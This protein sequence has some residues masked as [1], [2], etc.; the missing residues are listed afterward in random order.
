MVSQSSLSDRKNSVNTDNLDWIG[1]ISL[2][3]FAFSLIVEL[4]L[5][6][7][8]QV[9]KDIDLAIIIISFVVMLITLPIPGRESRIAK[10]LFFFR[11]KLKI[12]S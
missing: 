7:A 8:S 5:H 4:F 9:S 6:D 2:T 10:I 12:Q 3:V 1:I 11:K